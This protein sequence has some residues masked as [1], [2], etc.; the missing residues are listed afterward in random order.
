MQGVAAA[1]EPASLHVPDSLQGDLRSDHAG[2]QQ[3][4]HIDALPAAAG[5]AAAPLRGLLRRL[6]L[7]NEICI[8]STAEVRIS[9]SHIVAAGADVRGRTVGR[10]VVLRCDKSPTDFGCHGQEIDICSQ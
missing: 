1:F 2:A 7:D 5:A 9:G 8:K 6:N 4:D 10:G 3:I